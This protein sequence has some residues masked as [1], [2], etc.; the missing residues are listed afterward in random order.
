MVHTTAVLACRLGLAG[1]LLTTLVATAIAG[2]AA[3]QELESQASRIF[4]PVQGL[5]SLEVHAI[6]QDAQGMMWFATSGGTAS[7]NGEEFVTYDTLDLGTGPQQARAESNSV[8]ADPEVGVWVAAGRLAH[9]NPWSGEVTA[10]QQVAATTR[11]T[12]SGPE[13]L[14]V[15]GPSTL[16]RWLLGSRSIEFSLEID[17]DVLRPDILPV[18]SDAEGRIYLGGRTGVAVVEPDGSLREWSVPSGVSALAE[19][20]DGQVVA[21]SRSGLW[22]IRPSERPERIAAL[23]LSRGRTAWSPSSALLVRSD[24]TVW[25][26]DDAGVLHVFGDDDWTEFTGFGFGVTGE[27]KAIFEDSFGGLWA[28]QTGTGLG[29]VSDR[30]KPFGSIPGAASIGQPDTVAAVSDLTQHNGSLVAATQGAGLQR[31]DVESQLWTE[32]PFR[33]GSPPRIGEIPGSDS[34]ASVSS[35]Q[36]GD[37]ALWVGTWGDGLFQLLPGSD[38]A[39]RLPVERS[40][41]IYDIVDDTRGGVWVSNWGEGALQLDP[42]G[43]VVRRLSPESVYDTLNTQVQV[44]VPRGDWLFLGGKRGLDVVDLTRRQTRSF[45]SGGD[46]LVGGDVLDLY[47]ESDT[48]LWLVTDAGLEYLDIGREES[49]VFG[50]ESGLPAERITHLF[51]HRSRPAL[52]LATSQGLA[53]FDIET[54][55]VTASFNA[56]AGLPAPPFVPAARVV[57]DDGSTYLTTP[58]A[59]AVVPADLPPLTGDQERLFI[60]CVSGCGSD[61]DG[62]RARPGQADLGIEFFAID[63]STG[64]GAQIEYRLTPLESEW[65]VARPGQRIAQ[66][67]DLPVGDYTFEARLLASDGS[68][69]MATSRD[70]PGGSLQ[71]VVAQPI[72]RS[73]A[74][75]V[76]AGLTAAALVAG[77]VVRRSVLSRRHAHHLATLVDTRTQELKGAVRVAE[78][79]NEAKTRF[80]SSVTHELRSP[81]TS[82]IGYAELLEARSESTKEA[83]W[84]RS[85]KTAGSHLETMINDIL[86]FTASGEAEL[87]IA[88]EP[89]DVGN[90]INEIARLYQ[91]EASLRGMAIRC[92]VHP[93]TIG[94]PVL[95]D[96]RRARQVLINLVSN[97]LRHSGGE[98]LSLEVE[99]V[100]RTSSHDVISFRVTDDGDGIPVEER[101]RIFE[102]WN[103]GTQSGGTGLGLGLAISREVVNALG[104]EIQLESGEGAT[105]FSFDLTLERVPRPDGSGDKARVLVV[106]DD[107]AS[108]DVVQELAAALGYVVAAVESGPAALSTIDS[109]APTLVLTDVMMEPMSGVELAWTIRSLARWRDLPIVA[110]T[111]APAGVEASAFDAVVAKPFGLTMLS[112]TVE[113]LVGRTAHR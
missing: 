19:G 13:A 52:W 51:P 73:T 100:E 55:R 34:T 40:A 77:G 86:H 61:F 83:D 113:G 31:Y 11:V 4:G 99:L 43:A 62:S 110:M 80:L 71:I 70:E 17:Q 84:A 75:R 49:K 67:S 103:R 91:N 24:G 93:E 97:A 78:E 54:E 41:F 85:I 16:E 12:P 65:I 112:D 79:A 45:A 27:V 64:R 21:S 29:Y 88:P 108:R 42:N 106:D 46:L 47:A 56:D 57:A 76:V 58:T 81:L 72:W 96:E 3:G 2:P 90:L 94:F 37:G 107:A 111:A 14:W 109:F 59:V 18:A 69:I 8:V 28:S 102:P 9:I 33:V 48:R 105:T 68:E 95:L 32:I 87:Q 22:R 44:L 82:V 20:A 10:Y 36:G 74:F 15:W 35:I 104:G 7:W 1:V 89:A 60:R 26:G 39:L 5:P 23:G 53:L 6:E 98:H 25:V 63:G 92:E 50:P 30:F 66:Y 101:E 38:V